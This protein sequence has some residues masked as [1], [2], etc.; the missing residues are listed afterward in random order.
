MKSLKNFLGHENRP[1]VDNLHLKA[2]KQLYDTQV[3]AHSS[4]IRKENL[5]KIGGPT[6]IYWVRPVYPTYNKIYKSLILPLLHKI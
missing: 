6:I 2:I 1:T 4:G 3:W 5:M